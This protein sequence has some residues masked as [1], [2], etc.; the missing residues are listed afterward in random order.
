MSMVRASHRYLQ[1]LPLSTRCQHCTALKALC[2]IARQ[3][4][5]TPH[6]WRRH[7][8]CCSSKLAPL[9]WVAELV[10]W[11]LALAG[12]EVVGRVRVEMAILLIGENQ[13][14]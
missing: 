1:L 12:S 9:V 14:N 8:N 5:S 11:V 2:C 3:A 6:I 7:P 4:L 13:S 10:E